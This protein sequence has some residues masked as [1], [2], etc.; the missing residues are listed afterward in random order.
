MS[1]RHPSRRADAELRALCDQWLALHRE[2]ER[3]FAPYADRVGGPSDEAFR[4]FQARAPH[5]HALLRRIAEIPAR[6]LVGL[7]A[8]A[9]VVKAQTFLDADGQPGVD[10][11]VAH[12]LATDL[13]ALPT[14]GA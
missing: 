11:A 9:E 14:R 3:A 10:G 13:L 1:D 12:S 7:Q 8:K 5:S 6:T 4:W 2:V